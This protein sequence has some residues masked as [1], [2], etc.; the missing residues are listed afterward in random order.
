[1]EPVKPEEPLNPDEEEVYEEFYEEDEELYSASSS[2]AD[3]S[4]LDFKY[5][6]PK[7]G[8]GY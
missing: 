3:D 5:I 4:D 2:F 6:C 8:K 7:C 1:M